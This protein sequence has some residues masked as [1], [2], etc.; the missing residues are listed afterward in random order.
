MQACSNRC[1]AITRYNDPFK[2][3]TFGLMKLTSAC[4]VEPLDRELPRSAHLS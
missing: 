1:D 3:G 4:C 2:R